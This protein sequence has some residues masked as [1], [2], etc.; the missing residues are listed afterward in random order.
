MIAVPALVLRFPHDA[1]SELR[2]LVS[3]A[4]A[5]FET[6]AIH[7]VEDREWRAF[8]RS[9]AERDRAAAALAALCAVTPL[10]V[11]DEDWARRS[12]ADLRA[13]A[14]GE[15]IVAPPWDVPARDQSDDR[16]RVI[17][18][19]PS[20]G[21]G[22]GH[23]AT[24]RLCLRALQELDLRGKRVIDLGTG[25]G[26]LAIAAATL[27]A[28]EVIAVDNDPDALA[29]ARDNVARNGV[30]VTLRAADLE[31]DAL[32]AADVV[33]ANLTGAM[34][35]RQA[36]RLARLAR[37]GRLIVSGFLDEEAGAVCKAFERHGS[38]ARLDHENGWSAL[39]LTLS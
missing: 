27:G 2:D 32:P 34:L 33:L 16:A 37:G 28:R 19:E 38:D 36:A 18:I 17:V 21:F 3:A 20:T 26:L 11:E 10:D 12:Q 9:A 31:S 6:A 5:D 39:T 13:V 1:P 14:V 23:H 24:T 4:L 22:T 8:F 30:A 35:R 29:A 25:S 15:L 7:E